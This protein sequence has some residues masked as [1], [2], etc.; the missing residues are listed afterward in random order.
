MKVKSTLKKLKSRCTTSRR[1]LDGSHPSLFKDTTLPSTSPSQQRTKSS[2]AIN[3]PIAFKRVAREYASCRPPK[4]TTV[5]R[6]TSLATLNEDPQ[7]SFLPLVLSDS[8]TLAGPATPIKQ[9]RHCKDQDCLVCE[10]TRP[11]VKRR[12]KKD[13]ELVVRFVF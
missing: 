7:P 13:S 3:P 10:M 4:P 5:I 1:T 11:G 6:R 12:C 9:K 2:S 8:P